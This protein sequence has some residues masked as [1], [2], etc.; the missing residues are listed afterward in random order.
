[1][2]VIDGDDPRRAEIDP[3]IRARRTA[4]ARDAGRRRLRVLASVGA[5]L[6]LLPVGWLVTRTPLLD[7][8]R[9]EVDGA[10]RTGTETVREA[11]AIGDGAPLLDVDT[12]AAAARVEA[13]PWVARAKVTRQPPGDVRIAV[14]ERAPAAVVA[15]DGRL[16]LVDE[17]GRVLA[18]VASAPAGLVTVDGLAALPAPGDQVP[19]SLRPALAVALRVAAALE[20]RA[21]AV[22]STD[23]GLEV[24]LAEGGLAL[25]G[26]ADDL[27]TKLVALVAVLDQVD[28][29]CLERVDVRVPTSPV[30]TRGAGCG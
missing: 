23:G 20:E 1:M 29:G 7:V 19:E 9:I 22:R 16:A 27:D 12:G 5:L 14:E 24:S 21:A 17:T 26:T 18:G 3:R 8:D 2:T 25:L 30:L 6:A 4:V 13:L 15:A 10:A 28:R 11:A